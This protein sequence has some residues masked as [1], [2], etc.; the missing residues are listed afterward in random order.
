MNF[1]YSFIYRAVKCRLKFK[2]PAH[3]HLISRFV[4]S[5]ITQQFTL[6]GTLENRLSSRHCAFFSKE[7]SLFFILNTFKK[8]SLFL[9]SLLVKIN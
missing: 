4:F 7:S 9:R 3:R 2:A 1:S 5:N 8:T 6:N